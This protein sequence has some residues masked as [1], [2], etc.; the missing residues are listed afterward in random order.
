MVHKYRQHAPARDGQH[1]TTTIYRPESRRRKWPMP[2][3]FLSMNQKL[4]WNNSVSLVTRLPVTF[5]PRRNHSNSR[6]NYSNP[7]LDGAG[8][9]AL[10]PQRQQ[11]QLCQ[12]ILH[13]QVVLQRR[14]LL[15]VLEMMRLWRAWQRTGEDRWQMRSRSKQ[16]LPRRF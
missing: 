15:S 5:L 1:L 10:S 11:K 14:E 16:R 7:S 4:H 8:L 3:I 2:Q 9:T 6:N 13:I 12:P